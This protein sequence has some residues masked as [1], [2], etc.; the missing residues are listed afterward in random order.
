ML[1]LFKIYYNIDDKKEDYIIV[2][3]TTM[4]NAI[5]SFEEIIGFDPT[6]CLALDEYNGKIIISNE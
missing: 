3:A 6:R 2:V 1:N 5:K 4:S